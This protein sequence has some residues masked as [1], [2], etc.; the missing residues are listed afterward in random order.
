[1]STRAGRCRSLALTIAAAACA[2]ASQEPALRN[3]VVHYESRRVDQLASEGLRVDWQAVSG[4]RRVGSIALRPPE[5]VVAA[6]SEA[7]R[8][9]ER[10]S[11]QGMLEVLE[12]ESGRIPTGVD[13]P[14]AT[15]ALT[16]YG[17]RED[18]SFAEA[19]SGFEV[20][21][22]LLGD[23]RVR[24]DLAP[25]DGRLGPRAV[26]GPIGER[27]AAT[28]TVTLA[29]GAKVAVGGLARDSTSSGGS[30]FSGIGRAE[31]REERVLVVWVEVE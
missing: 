7:G 27:S 12:G 9:R 11:L 8:E 3:I 22:Q 15:R 24:L 28:T 16:P 17:V 23:G 18:S 25:F 20:T 5:T 10:G 14:A 19:E 21:P 26:G 1:M 6:R 4:K 2:E 30:L 31:V 29:P 13:V